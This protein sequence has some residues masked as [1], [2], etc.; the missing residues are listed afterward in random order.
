M[1]ASKNSIL[2]TGVLWIH[3]FSIEESYTGYHS[4]TYNGV[5]AILNSPADILNHRF[6]A[7]INLAGISTGISNNTLKF[8]YKN[9]KDDYGGMSWPNPITKSGKAYFNTDIFG[10]SFLIRLSDKNAF[11]VTTRARV[12]TNIH[13]V[14]KYILNSVLQD[15]ID[16]SLI[17]TKLSISDL[18]V[19]AHAWQE[20]AFTYSRQVALDDYGVWKAGVSLKYLGGLAA[21]NFN[22]NN[23]SFV[24]DSVID[25]T[26]GR[27]KDALYNMNGSVAIRYSSNLDSIVSNAAYL[28]FKNPGVGIDIG[29]SYEHRDE[30][31]VYE[32][33]YSEKT[34]SYNWRIGA[35]ITDIGF[36]RYK[37]QNTNGLSASASGN[38]YT[39][40]QL[41]P[42]SDS[43]DIYQLSNYYKKLFN[44]TTGPSAFTMQLPTTLHLTYDRFFNKVLAV[45]AQLNIPLVFS[46][47]N[48]YTGNYNPVA[49]TVTPR[50]E[51]TWAGVYMPFSYNSVSGLQVGTALRLG[52]L[53]IGSASLINTRMFKTKT[54]DLYIILRIPF[55]GYRE[56]KNKV[57]S[58]GAGKLTKKQRR[59]LDCP[60]K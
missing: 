60:G 54:T 59:A 47:L 29:V 45:N 56:Y 53:V 44:A 46:Q 41:T 55:F 2:L 9:R 31:Q 51:I 58:D 12:V 19:N 35:S 48:L 27:N 6:R 49:V 32:T 20:I 23:L 18:A 39:T 14:S 15:T 30:M 4:A 38:T 26:T 34:A 25:A 5:Y 57:F 33:S 43:S 10:P 11:A 52:P 8:T 42:P 3:F 7:D 40:D 50:A 36:I 37:A 17:G 22:T 24:H 21:V 13:G 28:S 16:N 1:F